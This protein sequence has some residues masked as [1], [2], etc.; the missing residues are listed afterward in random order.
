MIILV[1]DNEMS[2]SEN[3]GGL[4][5][6]LALLRQTKG[7]A[8]TNFFK[9]LNFDYYYLDNGHNLDALIET[10]S[11]VK[12]TP[13]P[14]V[15]HMRTLKGKGYE[16]AETLKEHYHYT[17]PFNMETGASLASSP[18]ESYAQITDDF[19]C[20]K[21]AQDKKI[22]AI[23][24][25]TPT[26]AHNRFRNELP[27]QFIDVGIAEEHAIAL[28][29]GIASQGGKPV[30]SFYSSFIQ[31]TYDQ[32]SQDLAINQN[33]ALILVHGSGISGSDITHLGLFDIPLIANIP[34]LVYL[35]PTHKEEYLAMMEWGIEQN[36][37]PVIIKVPNQ[38]VISTGKK[39][40][41]D[42]STLNKY[43]RIIDGS[44]VAIIALGSFY[45][46]GEKIHTQLQTDL[47]IQS[48]LIN[49]R[50]MTGID[51]E[52]LTE[53]LANHQLVITLEDGILDGGFGEKITRF[54]GDKDMKVL[55]FGAKKEF[56]DRVP[57]QELYERY[58]LTEKQVIE[59]IKRTI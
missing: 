8:E 37:Y 20:D 21:A 35:A 40:N 26:L 32:L 34:N 36:Q 55:N 52:Q 28:A 31:R 19:L 11:Q 12:D 14:T 56:T 54:Y 3:S 16:P 50:Y 24:A 17:A 27:A 53:L 5:Q 44:K 18:T 57:V 7:L 42:F 46:L 10:F 30:A 58:Q 33:P 23:T 25:A 1:N 49:P 13:K 39:V 41:A 6:N 15:I 4:Y 59:A 51:Q 45:P 38:E 9:A 29:S 22:V 2:I 48:T 43:E 47:G